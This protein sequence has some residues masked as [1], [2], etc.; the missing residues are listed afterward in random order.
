VA[1]K[2]QNN[3]F[4]KQHFLNWLDKITDF[5]SASKGVNKFFFAGGNLKKK[6]I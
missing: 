1:E 5:K 2:K 3:R 6:K 4:K